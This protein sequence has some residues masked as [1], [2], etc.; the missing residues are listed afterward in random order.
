MD[1]E[2]GCMGMNHQLIDIR[3]DNCIK[4]PLKGKVMKLHDKDLKKDSFESVSNDKLDTR[5]AWF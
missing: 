3:E 1:C 5:K 2:I 4:K